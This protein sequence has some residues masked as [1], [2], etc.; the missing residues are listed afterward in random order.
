MKQPVV[1]VGGDYAVSAV[2]DEVAAQLRA[3]DVRVIR[4]RIEAPPKITEYAPGEWPELFADAD[5]IVISTRTRAPRAM[6]EAAPRLR[7]L[8]FPTI[9]TDSIALADAMDLGLVIGHGPTPE[10]FTGMAESTVML[11]AALFLDLSGKERM[12][13]QNLPR[14]QH[15]D[16]RARLVRGHTIGL[17]GMGRIARS[18]VARLQGWDVRILAH[19]PYVA[20]SAA[21]QGVTMV[22]MPTLLSQSDLI[23]IHVTLTDHTRHM[24]G[25]EE[26]R[27]MKPNAYLINTSRGGAI[28]ERALITALRSGQLGGAALDVFEH[29][30]LPADSPLRTLDN[31]RVISHIV[32]QVNEMHASFVN[33]A[34]ENIT[35]M[36][37]NEAPLYVRN[38]E[39]LP[40]W[41]KRLVRLDG[42]NATAS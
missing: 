11:M 30:P 14:P 26:L 36:L 7:G 28:D 12:T 42:G 37:R 29:E 15:R 35:R 39:V 19:D 22:D 27:Q 41:Q 9:G 4:G 21:P 10:N 38:P 17:I 31:V 20:Q 32:G 2:L 24:I 18:V 5:I 25:A 34:L 8:V 6:L 23:S 16:M 40:A 13:R 3:R 33:A 1:F